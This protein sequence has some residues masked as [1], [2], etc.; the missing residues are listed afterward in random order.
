[1]DFQIKFST[2]FH[3]YHQLNG[4]VDCLFGK[5]EVHKVLLCDPCGSGHIPWPLLDELVT[6][7]RASKNQS[8]GNLQSLNIYHQPRRH[9]LKWNGARL[10]CLVSPTYQISTHICDLER[11]F[12]FHPNGME[13]SQSDFSSYDWSNLPECTTHFFDI[14]F[15]FWI[16]SDFGLGKSRFFGKM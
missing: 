13:C 9:F 14:G 8:G 3:N 4:S 1:M 2:I 6:W 12:K 7:W 11:I 15:I 16:F 10:V 5:N